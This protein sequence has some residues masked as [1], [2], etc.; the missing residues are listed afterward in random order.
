MQAL[1][2]LWR[3]LNLH[4]G[5]SVWHCVAGRYVPDILKG[6]NAFIFRKQQSKENGML[7]PE[8]WDTTLAALSVTL[9]Q[10]TYIQ[11]AEHLTITNT[12]V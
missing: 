9:Y 8:D 3:L 5:G 11:M 10:L 7:D 6:H 2:F 12:A 1:K 4:R